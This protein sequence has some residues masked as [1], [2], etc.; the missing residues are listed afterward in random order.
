MLTIDAQV[1]YYEKDHPPPG[2]RSWPGRLVTGDEMVAAMDVVGVDGT[3][4]LAYNV[5]Y[6]ASYAL[7]SMRSIG[8]LALIKPVDPRSGVAE[9][10][11]DWVETEGTVAIRI[12]MAYRDAAGADDPGIHNV[13]RRRAGCRSREL[14]VLSGLAGAAAAANPDTQIVLDHSV[15]TVQAPCRT[16]RLPNCQCFEAGPKMSRLKSPAYRAYRGT[17]SQ[18]SMDPLHLRCFWLRAMPGARTGPGR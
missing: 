12:M 6:D 11:E 10:I 3:L 2:R 7:T 5:K 15:T 13:C 17:V 14:V 16:S 1:R 4:G 8:P 9:T 18:R